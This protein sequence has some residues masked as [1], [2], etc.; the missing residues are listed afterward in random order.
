M[1]QTVLRTL[2]IP[3]LQFVARWISTSR[4]WVVSTAPVSGSH[5]FDAGLSARVQYLDYSGR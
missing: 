2:E 1:V 4:L 3:Q 5:L